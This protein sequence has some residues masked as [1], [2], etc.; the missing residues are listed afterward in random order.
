MIKIVLCLVF[1]CLLVRGH[2]WPKPTQ[3]E[4]GNKFVYVNPDILKSYIP[5]NYIVNKGFERYY[6]LFFPF[7]KQFSSVCVFLLFKNKLC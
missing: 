3:A 2:L 5:S 7:I 1:G 4:Y 6:D